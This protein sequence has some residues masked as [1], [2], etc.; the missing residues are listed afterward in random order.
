[1]GEVESES[2]CIHGMLYVRHTA[3]VCTELERERE[4]ERTAR[5]EKR[6]KE[7]EK[8]RKKKTF[9]SRN[10]WRRREEEDLRH[11]LCCS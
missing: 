4:K 10:V 3:H 1:M 9:V 8:G 7:K 11:D 2:Q 5:N 6:A